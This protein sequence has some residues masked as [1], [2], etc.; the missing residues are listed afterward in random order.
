M[1]PWP[2]QSTYNVAA[3]PFAFAGA[4]VESVDPG[5]WLSFISTL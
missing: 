5:D 2:V 1:V 3:K 4:R